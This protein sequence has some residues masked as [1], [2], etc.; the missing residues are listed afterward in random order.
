[1]SENYSAEIFRQ[2][3]ETFR[4]ICLSVDPDGSV[5]LDAQ[6]M[7]KLVQRVWGDDDYEFW[8]DVPASALPKLVFSRSAKNILTEV[9]PWMS[10]SHFVKKKKS[11]T[12]G[13]VG[14]SMQARW[15]HRRRLRLNFYSHGHDFNSGR[16]DTSFKLA[17][18]TRRFI[19]PF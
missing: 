17:T 15:T 5:K 8:V 10:S 13:K 12:N 11:N 19:S 16:R 1:M 18:T 14:S 3:G 4:S 7:G 9:G 2:T 6:D